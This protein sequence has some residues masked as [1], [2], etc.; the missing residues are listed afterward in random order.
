MEA[1]RRWARGPSRHRAGHAHRVVI[2]GGGFAGLQAVH[3]LRKADAEVTLVDRR[4]FH[5]FQPLVYQVATGALFPAEISCPL[6]RIFRR[7]RNV[8]VVLAEV[9]D[10]ELDARLVRLRPV[11]GE[12][13][14][15]SLS[16]DTL[17]VSAG[18]HYNYFHHEH[19]QEVAANLRTLEGALTIRRRTPGGVRG[20]R[21]G[22]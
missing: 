15:D 1:R 7:R 18:S 16:Y 4:N 17:I 6:R 12:H 19:W 5:L 8:E 9:S 14:P 2:I 21:A 20:R 22:A 11:A 10:V 13:V 3:G